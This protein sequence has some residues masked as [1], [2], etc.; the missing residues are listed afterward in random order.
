[1]DSSGEVDPQKGLPFRTADQ[2]AYMNTLGDKDPVLKVA[3]KNKVG[4][5]S[6]DKGEAGKFE[7]LLIPGSQYNRSPGGPGS[8]IKKENVKVLHYK[9]GRKEGMYVT[10]NALKKG[11]KALYALKARRPSGPNETHLNVAGQNKFPPP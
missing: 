2:S 5:L 3:S 4:V 11:Y 7:V 10:Y 6:I 8:S 9:G 1:V